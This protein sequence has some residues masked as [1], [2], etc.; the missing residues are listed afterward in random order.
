MEMA[1][2][3]PVRTS[4]MVFALKQLKVGG[5]PGSAHRMMRE[6]FTFFFQNTFGVETALP[7]CD[8]YRW[9][10]DVRLGGTTTYRRTAKETVGSEAQQDFGTNGVSERLP[11]S[12]GGRACPL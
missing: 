7:T 12:V 2:A 11:P 9:F 3:S 8:G 10:H 4:G 6:T 1:A 5:I